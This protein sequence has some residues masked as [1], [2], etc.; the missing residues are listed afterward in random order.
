V[1]RILLAEDEVVTA[2]ALRGTLTALGHEVTVAPDGLLAWQVV[3]DQPISVVI[4]DWMMPGL[5]GPSLCRRIRGMGDSPYIYFILIS[6]RDRQADRMEGLRAG[7]DD[8]LSKPFDSAELAVRLEIARRILA[9]QERLERQNAR[10]VE[11]ATT[12]DLTGLAN[13]REFLRSLKAHYGLAKRQG[14]PLSLVLMDI[15]Y[16]KDFNDSFGHP[17][18]DAALRAFAQTIRGACREHEPVARLGGEEFALMLLGA[19]REQASAAA[20]RIRRTLTARRWPHRPI[21]ASFGIA[22][23][24]P[25]IAGVDDLMEQADSALYLAKRHGRNRVMHRDDRPEAARVEVGNPVG[26]R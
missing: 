25:G 5:D 11:L 10:L 2:A 19:C 22:T 26:D 17:A 15:D 24:G 13:R 3:Q 6:V 18:G 21:T 12:D 23:T 14:V 7:A 8:F 16:F 4:S 20:E 1:L 9:V